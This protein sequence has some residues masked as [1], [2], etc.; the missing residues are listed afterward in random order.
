MRSAP[1]AQTA[2]WRG[3]SDVRCDLSGSWRTAL[4]GGGCVRQKTSSE[5]V[6][7]KRGQAW[8]T[9]GRASVDRWC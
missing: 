7:R 8:A 1:T 4:V 2:A 3:S 5:L 6:T 9:N